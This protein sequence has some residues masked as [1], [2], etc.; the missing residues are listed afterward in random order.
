MSKERVHEVAK[1]LGVSSKVVLAKLQE[2]GVFARSASSPLEPGNVAALEAAL[3]EATPPARP[4]GGGPRPSAEDLSA[5]AEVPVTSSEFRPTASPQF[6]YDFDLEGRFVVLPE[7]IR[8]GGQAVVRKALDMQ[9]HEF[10]AVKFFASEAD[11]LVQKFFDR[12]MASL[13]RLQHPNIVRL[14][15]HGTERASQRLFFVLEWVDQTL[16]QQLD[17]GRVFPFDE[18]MAR[19]GVPLTRA[20]A[21]AHSKQVEHRDI[22]PANILLRADGTAVLAD[23]GVAKLW[24][25]AKGD[26]TLHEY[27]SGVYAPPEVDGERLY[28]RDVYSLGVVMLRCMTGQAMRSRDDIQTALDAAAM[29]PAIRAVIT[30]CVADNPEDRPANGLILHERLN[31]VMRHGRDNYLAKNNF[32]LLGVTRTARTTLEEAD[33]EPTAR[34]AESLIQDDL[35]DDV[36]A[37]YRLDPQTGVRD[38]DKLEV[39]GERF[40]Y[41]LVYASDESKFVITSVRESEYEELERRR[42]KSLNLGR[43]FTWTTS[44]QADSAA[45]QAG[46]GLLLERLDGFYESQEQSALE[47]DEATVDAL[48][49]LWSRLLD[50]REEIERGNRAGYAFRLE[51]WDGRQGEFDIGTILD[52]DLVGSRMEI[53]EADGYRRGHAEVVDQRGTSL[54][55]RSD[56]VIRKVPRDGRLEPSIGASAFAINRQ[57]G[58]INA[59][60]NGLARRA[61]LAQVI[62][63]PE[64][65]RSPAPV[66]VSDW[67]NSTLDASKRA[68]VSAALGSQ[69]FLLVQGPPGTGKT[70]FI[71]EV[72][73]QEL[74]A[75]PLT[76]ILVVS[77]THVAVDNALERLDAQGVQQLVRLGNREDSIAES[78]RH[79][80]LDRQISEWVESMR[81]GATRNLSARAEAHG[82]K[83]RH[84]RAALALE[85]LAA[86]LR[87]TERLDAELRKSDTS[88]ETDLTTALGITG[89][90]AGLQD[91]I[92]RNARRQAELVA[93]IDTLLEGDLTISSES[94]AADA[95]AAVS[96][97]VGEDATSQQL[98]RLMEIQADWLQRVAGQEEMA[99]TFMESR[100][101][102]AGTNLGFLGHS[103]VRNIEFDLCIL[104]EASKATATESLVPLTKSARWILVGDDN[105]LPPMDEEVLRNHEVRVNFDLTEDDVITETL[106]KRLN[107]R[108]PKDCTVALQEQYRMIRPIGDMISTVFYGGD[109]RSPVTEGI[110]GYDSMGKAVLWLDTSTLG[111][112]RFEED[113][114]GGETSHANRTEASLCINRLVALDRAI[115]AGFIRWPHHRPVD[116][117]LIAPYRRQI[118][119]LRRRVGTTDLKHIRAM[120]MSVDAVQGREAD[121]AVFSVTR[122]NTRGTLGFLGQAYWRRINV[123]LSRARFGLTIVGDAPFAAS[124]PGGLRD[125]FQ[126][127]R[128]NPQDCEIREAEL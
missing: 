65:S 36:W 101:V 55:L 113:S 96:L 92:D 20:L 28:V 3:A 119:E 30:E 9:T 21:Y 25:A 104:D 85:E 63:H 45:V 64:D 106:F 33:E 5:A 115:E 102:V 31:S 41:M 90:T 118:E 50:A 100:R 72:V 125:V 70:S 44:R 23:F 80:L 29:P 46:A 58:A 47:R 26:L 99:A 6:E 40:R 2:L 123:A 59:V 121:L 97:L 62:V 81:A 12:E 126:Y 86:I 61:D 98:L 110:P 109:L 18:C 68:A 103:A 66:M 67:F 112:P 116:V 17:A 53:R 35:K 42:S 105:Q 43:S 10:V 11:G 78:T 94:N 69:D 27:R 127:M 19:I 13:S 76:R 122:S 73:R 108:L 107:A 117:L 60:R 88:S 84:L 54:V 82:V 52:V 22:K 14:I 39:L 89:D 57:R 34:S 120:A 24:D 75:N 32:I 49:D 51:R 91:R 87:E 79:L 7:P 8:R 4:P 15:A 111:S 48:F 93:E 38:R 74:A 83:P 1:R 56:R 37:Q 114:R 77:Q 124:A 95:R 71:T 128:Q 16:A